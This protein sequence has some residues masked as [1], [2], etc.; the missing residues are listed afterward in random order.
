MGE[1]FGYVSVDHFLVCGHGDRHPVVLVF[2]EVQAADAVHLDRRDRLAAPLCQ[3]EPFPA[4][5]HPV[6]GGT[7]PVVKSRR[8]E[9]ADDRA[10]PDGLQAELPA[11]TA[12]GQG[13]TVTGHLLART[14]RTASDPTRR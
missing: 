8:V 3:R 11:V 7:E 14:S 2:D 1:Y 10:Q 4:G 6:G 9:R 12:A 13:T 5:S